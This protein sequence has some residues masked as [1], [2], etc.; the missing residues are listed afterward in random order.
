MNNICPRN[1][2]SKDLKIIP[3]LFYI[4]FAT[5]MDRIQIL[6]V[7]T[8]CSHFLLVRYYVGSTH[9]RVEAF[10]LQGGFYH[11]FT[12]HAATP[13][14]EGLACQPCSKINSTIW[15]ISARNGNA[16]VMYYW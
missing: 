12:P 3:E 8:S 11:C 5:P 6:L 15:F 13:E 4:Q 7:I 2:L 1:T 14:L 9:R 10:P 16:T